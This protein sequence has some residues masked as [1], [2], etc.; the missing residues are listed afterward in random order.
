MPPGF[1]LAGFIFDAA[2][3]ISFGSSAW[4]AVD[5][6]SLAVRMRPALAMEFAVTAL[7]GLMTPVEAR[8]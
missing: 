4:S 6:N 3:K 5:P 2:I 8:L 1:C 7:F